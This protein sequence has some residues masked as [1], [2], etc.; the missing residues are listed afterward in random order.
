MPLGVLPAIQTVCAVAA[1]AAA[2]FAHVDASTSIGDFFDAISR[3]FGTAG[4]VAGPLTVTPWF[5]GGCGG[6]WGIHA[7]YYTLQQILCKAVGVTSLQFNHAACCGKDV[8]LSN[9]L[10]NKRASALATSDRPK[11][12][13]ALCLLDM[14]ISNLNARSSITAQ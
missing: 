8:A 12:T 11:F 9:N 3:V 6:D 2:L 7:L 4:G 14:S 1:L 10:S 5:T 13:A